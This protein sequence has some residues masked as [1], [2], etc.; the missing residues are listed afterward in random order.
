MHRSVERILTTHTGSLPRPAGVPLPGTAAALEGAE[1][2]EEQ[3]RQVVADTVRRQVDAGVDVVNDGEVSKPSY[4]TYVVNR[5]TGF[6]GEASET[7]VLQEAAEFP[8]FFQRLYQSISS[9]VMNPACTGPVRY[10]QHT[11]VDR[12]IANL[13][14]AKKGVDV[15][16]AF[17]TAASPGVIALFMPNRH[18]AGEQEYIVALAAAMK[19]E[20]DAI[21]RSGLL[22]QIDCPDLAAGW[23][24]AE[25]RGRSIDDF[26]RIA[27][28]HIE[29][30][31]DATR[32]IPPD[33]M[34]MHMCWGNYEGPHHHDLPLAAVIDLVLKA[35]PAGL[36]FENANPRH[37]HEWTVFEDV[38][39]PDGKVLIPGVLDSTNNYIEHPELV[40]QRIERLARL[41][42]RDNV[43]AGSDCGFA[44]FAQVLPV[45]PRIT[46]AKL[47]AMAEGAR[48]ASGRLWAGRA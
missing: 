32:D 44:T 25:A 1:A 45:D 21:H 7:V 31:N 16:E 22:L 29:A 9:A 23:P 42:G 41:V 43:M 47:S 10:K 34:R 27:A 24:V 13:L 40:A 36:L 15:T 37:E 35:R 17:M 38:D 3:I 12:D 28:Q 39:V 14:E 2:S 19:E 8:E 20:Y 11:E 6:E 5:L 18:Y 4:A 30:L 33:R 26:R 46:W 48:L